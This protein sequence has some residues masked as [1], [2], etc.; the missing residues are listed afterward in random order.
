MTKT[1]FDG[2]QRLLMVIGAIEV[3]LGLVFWSGHA[4]AL[5]QVALWGGGAFALLLWAISG[6]CARAGAPRG[7]VI[8]GFATGAALGALEWAQATLFPEPQ[9][10][11]VRAA[12]VV[13]LLIGMGVSAELAASADMRRLDYPGH[14]TPPVTTS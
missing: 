6:M 10:W 13:L 11:I 1:L 12:Q 7:L 14:K 5:T 9:T 8:T 4:L 2:S 3:V